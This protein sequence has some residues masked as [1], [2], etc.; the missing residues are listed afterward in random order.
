M[1]DDLRKSN[2]ESI[3]IKV[4]M[5]W[6][7]EAITN[8]K[9]WAAAIATAWGASDILV[10][11]NAI[12]PIQDAAK[13]T[14]DAAERI[15]PVADKAAK[16]GPKLDNIAHEMENGLAKRIADRLAPMFK[17]VNDRLDKLDERQSRTERFLF[18]QE[19]GGFVPPVARAE[20][21]GGG[22]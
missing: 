4:P 21:A 3:E 18:G 9:L 15:A 13:Q 16:V 10:K 22:S 12:Q 5:R 2:G 20:D 19:N 6:L 8:W 1:T 7:R 11:V 17:P 14:S